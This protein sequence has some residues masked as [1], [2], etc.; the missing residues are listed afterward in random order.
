MNI[1]TTTFKRIIKPIPKIAGG[2]I[3]LYIASTI[4]FYSFTMYLNV[5]NIKTISMPTLLFSIYFIALCF[6]TVLIH[7]GSAFAIDRILKSKRYFSK[8][9]GFSL[10]EILLV[11]AIAAALV[12][13]AFVIYPK[14]VMSQRITAES[15]NITAIQAG[16]QSLYAGRAKLSTLNE[17]QLIDSKSIPE[18][19][20]QNGKMINEWK[21]EVNVQYSGN[22]GKYNIIYNNV[23]IEAC[24]KFITAVSGNFVSITIY[25]SGGS[26]DIKNKEESFEIDTAKTAAG[27]SAD[28]SS[29]IYFSVEK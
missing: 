13:G 25:N 20:L 18:N 10:L 23:P 1:I 16:V 12:I 3:S 27:C 17:Q 6:I 19:M 21:G 5:N 7:K 2:F 14:I 11:L 8:H 9:K 4:C 29:T 15:K 24:S 22:H 26:F 28:Q